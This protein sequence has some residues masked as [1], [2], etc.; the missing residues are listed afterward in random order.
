[1]KKAGRPTVEHK[2]DIE[3]R[4][5]VTE[6]ENERLEALA[7]KLKM[8][9]SRMIRNIVLGDIGDYEMLANIGVLPIVQ[10]ALAFYDK[11][12]KNEDFY[13]KIKSEI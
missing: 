8:N 13:E 10:R 4:F 1:M 9:K 7:E 12:F 5:R 6:E 11:N 3:I 2:R